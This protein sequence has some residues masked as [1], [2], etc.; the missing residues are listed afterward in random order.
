MIIAAALLTLVLAGLFFVGFKRLYTLSQ[1]T[2]WLINYASWFDNRQPFL[3]FALMLGLLGCVLISTVVYYP[4][5]SYNSAAAPFS[6]GKNIFWLT[7]FLTGMA[8]FGTQILLFYFSFRFRSKSASTAS[9]F[10]G[11]SKLELTW[12]VVPA[13]CFLGLFFWNQIL[14]QRITSFKETDSVKIEVVGEQFNWKVRYG[15]HDHE[16]G[17]TSFQLVSDTNPLGIDQTDSASL[18]DFMPV[19]MH[20]PK[21]RN[22][23]LVLRSKDVIHSFYVPFFRTK[24]DAVPGMHTRM[25]FTALYSTAEMR[26]LRNDPSFNYEIACAELCGRMH[27]AM[28]MILVVDEPE[29]FDAWYNQQESWVSELARNKLRLTTNA[30]YP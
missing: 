11:S 28:K 16:L 24:M 2:K 17:K 29:E 21:G 6:D 5:Y 15:G 18:D 1:Q 3:L 13:I 25:Q 8:F 10:R 4:L 19:Q 7:V 9:F 22:V 26:E 14:W 12:T 20:V 30:Q 27:F 23:T